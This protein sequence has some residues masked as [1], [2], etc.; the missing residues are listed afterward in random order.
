ME[1]FLP[2]T[3]LANINPSEEQII[4]K[5]IIRIFITYVLRAC[6]LFVR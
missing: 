6:F 4:Y 3:I 1:P 2:P 5:E